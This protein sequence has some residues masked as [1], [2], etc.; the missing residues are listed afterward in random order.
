M[1]LQIM[2]KLNL[3]NIRILHSN[4][5]TTRSVTQKCYLDAQIATRYVITMP[6]QYLCEYAFLTGYGNKVQRKKRK[7][8]LERILILHNICG[9][10]CLLSFPDK[11]VVWCHFNHSRKRQM[12]T[13]IIWSFFFFFSLRCFISLCCFSAL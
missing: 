5:L 7:K 9:D 2:K 8:R 6:L 13:I 10:V 4:S 12:T 3:L 1:L 11:L